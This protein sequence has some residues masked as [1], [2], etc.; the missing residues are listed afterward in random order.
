M[1]RLTIRLHAEERALAKK[2][3]KALGI[4]LAGFV[5]GA[6]RDKL[7]VSSPAPWLRYAGMVSSGDLNSSLS[8]DDLVY[9]SK[10]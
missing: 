10:D 4:S 5:R 8:I 9:G 2:E 7:L 6:V 3:S 1:T